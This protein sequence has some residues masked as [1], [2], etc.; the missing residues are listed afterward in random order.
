[1]SQNS[2]TRGT[3][4]AT[5]DMQSQLALMTKSNEPVSLAEMPDLFDTILRILFHIF[6]L[7]ISILALVA[8]WSLT[9]RAGFAVFLI[10]TF[11]FYVILMLCSWHGRP[12]QSILTVIIF[13]LRASPAP[14]TPS[15]LPL[16][17]IDGYPFPTDVR[18]PYVHHQPPFHVT[19]TDEVSTT[20]GHPR[21]AENEDDDDADEDVRQQRIEDEM[22]RRDVSIITVPRK[23]LW[24]TN[25]ESGDSS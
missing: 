15:P 19:G 18:G 10:C 3:T 22:A 17:A 7:A 21:S 24:I 5:A 12:R 1:M 16:S 9:S 20:H 25:P 11:T 23:K 2:R 13:R 14:A 8:L 6:L 4:P